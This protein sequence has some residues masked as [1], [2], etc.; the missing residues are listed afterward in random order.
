[1][2]VLFEFFF[3]PF[4][5]FDHEIFASELVVVGEVIDNLMISESNP[6]LKDG[7]P[8]LGLKRF[9]VVQTVAQ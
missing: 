2:L 1:M 7:L 5:I 4:K 3:V 8:D 6:Y 9:R